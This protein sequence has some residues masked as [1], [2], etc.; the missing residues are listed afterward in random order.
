MFGPSWRTFAG[1][2]GG[3]LAGHLL[4]A[5]AELTGAPPRAVTAHLL[6]GVL[7]DRPVAVSAVPD[8]TGTTSS[9]R[10]ELRQD[11]DL[12][13]LAQVLTLDRP[14]PGVPAD[15]GPAVADGE[16]LA[17]PAELVP[18]AVHTEVR[19]LGPDR[20]LAGGAEPRLHAWVRLPDLADP[21]VHLAAAVDAL[22]PSLFA[23]WTAPRALPTVELTVHLTGLVPPAGAW[24]RVD[25]RT[26]WCDDAVAV[27]DARLWDADGR[28]VG[29]S[30]QTRRLLG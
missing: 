22:P 2:Q 8:R 14:L 23:V 26:T 12:R 1:V 7:P 4:A 5:A 21:L 3:L 10:A 13:V 6:R 24:L 11:G 16:P 18:I 25:Q 9:V 27:D 29:W 30:R 20:P 15:D 19:A 17:L 28:P